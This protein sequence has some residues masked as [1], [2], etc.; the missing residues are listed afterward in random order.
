MLI[1]MFLFIS[2]KNE[3]DIRKECAE[4]HWKN[5]FLVIFF[6]VHQTEKIPK[7]LATKVNS[8]RIIHIDN[9]KK[10]TQRT[11]QAILNG[12]VINE[13]KIDLILF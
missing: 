7:H 8:S 6:T 13:N 4:M 11:Y 1:T 5:V 10:A 3:I 12:L 2:P 9:A